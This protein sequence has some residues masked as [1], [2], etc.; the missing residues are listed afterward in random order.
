MSVAAF[1]FCDERAMANNATKP[2]WRESLAAMIAGKPKKRAAPKGSVG[3]L[4]SFLMQ[5]NS[6]TGKTVTIDTALQ[7]SAVLACV[8]VI[9]EDTAMAPFV[10]KSRGA[11]GRWEAADDH[12]TARLM[13]APNEW[14]TGI[15]FRSMLTAH[16]ALAHGGFAFINR[17]G[18]RTQELLPFLP[19]NVAV[20]RDDQWGITYR[21]RFPSGREELI[22]AKN[23]FHLRGPSWDGV[24]GLEVFKLAREAIGIALATEESHARLHANG[25]RLSGIL[26]TGAGAPELSDEAATRIARQWK[27]EFGGDGAN[28]FGVAVLEGGM[29]FEPMSMSGVDAQHIE[30]RR[31]QVEEICR[32][33]RV[34]PQMIGHADKAAT[35]ASAE[36]FFLS[37]FT[38]TIAPWCERWSQRVD[39]DILAPSSEPRTWV[40]FDIRGLG[41]GDART[42]AAYY[43]S[44]IHA[45]WLNRNEAREME[46][47]E[48]R[49]GL[50][51]YLLP[52]N[53][54]PGDGADAS[55]ARV[56]D[57]ASSDSSAA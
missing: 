48:P 16:A 35:F 49:E 53:L 45:G 6:A 7:V 40:Y 14:Q 5:P 10:V 17:I 44:G 55:N 12:W 31:F 38:H 32:A 26:T 50:D 54:A 19:Q 8:R 4:H 46:G 22:P 15:E 25:V 13:R 11:S 52:V 36:Q 28:E 30:T 27:E 56:D 51:E 24:R 3:W 23:M 2:T 9:A 34:Y 42:R 41:R 20:E 21:V 39:R 37:H 57:A 18:G 43:N 33:M 47:L 29:K 1:S